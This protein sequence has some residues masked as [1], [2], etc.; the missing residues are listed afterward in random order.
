MFN[1]Q[2]NLSLEYKYLNVKKT[3][4][5][6]LILKIGEE[7]FRTGIC[8]CNF[9][10][11]ADYLEMLQYLHPQ[12]LNYFKTLTIEKRKKSYLLGRYS[13][14][15]AISIIAGAENPQ[16]F[17]IKHGF[18]NQPIVINRNNK[19]VQISI[20]HCEDIGAAVAFPETLP[21]GIDI[22]KVDPNKA[23]IIES[24]L[25]E[26]EKNLIKSFPYSYNAMLT[27]LWTAKEALSKIL[28]TGMMT[29][30]QIYELTSL[31]EKNNYIICNFN[32]FAQYKGVSFNLGC[33]MCTIVYPRVTDIYLNIN[34]LKNAFLFE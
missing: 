12:E 23:N 3:Y 20:S 22:E 33:Y 5:S 1:N 10:F 17:F 32:N 24:Q 31:T 16:S 7:T 30:F 14:K 26:M 4:T 34:N 6:E 15:Q 21:M 27:L 2:V 8:F 29:P 28:K 25:T 18:F 9:P 11:N 19:N 13:A